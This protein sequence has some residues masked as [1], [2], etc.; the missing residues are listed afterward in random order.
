MPE[1]RRKV[2]RKM[3]FDLV[4]HDPDAL[5]SIIVKQHKDQAV[6][7]ANDAERRQTA[8]QRD[9]RSVAVAGT[10][11]Q[12]SAVTSTTHVRVPRLLV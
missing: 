5:L 10:K 12:G 2:E 3:R 6:V 8:K 1:F 9:A 11:P 4:K 7:E